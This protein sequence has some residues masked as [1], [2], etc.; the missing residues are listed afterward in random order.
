MPVKLRH[1]PRGDLRYLSLTG[2]FLAPGGLPP[3]LRQLI[4]RLQRPMPRI[5]R[6]GNSTEAIAGTGR[7]PP[8]PCR[9]PGLV[10]RSASSL[11]QEPPSCLRTPAMPQIIWHRTTC[12]CPV[13]SE[14]AP[15]RRA[16]LRCAI[17]RERPA[18]PAVQFNWRIPRRR[19]SDTAPPVGRTATLLLRDDARDTAPD[20][21]LQRSSTPTPSRSPTPFA[22][23][24]EQ[25]RHLL[26]HF[27][28]TA[29]LQ[30][31]QDRYDQPRTT[32]LKLQARNQ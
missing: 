11:W 24:S 9:T 7:E 22:T 32:L 15:R 29:P 12:Q 8:P 10:I 6:T 1:R 13:R 21:D 3:T 14:L 28:R 30:P 2:R 20:L 23:Q 18:P 25:A 26:R 31:G 19:A 4:E 5:I 27:I 17:S 16:D